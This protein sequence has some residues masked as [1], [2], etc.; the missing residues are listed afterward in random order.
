VTSGPA[1]F[2][3]TNS[4][5]PSATLNIVNDGTYTVQLFVDN[6]A[7]STGT[8]VSKT[9][10]VSANSTFAQ[11]SAVF[12]NVNYGCTGCHAF[13][14]GYANNPDPAVNSGIPPSWQSPNDSNGKT[15]YQ[16]VL[17]RVNLGSPASSLLL[18]NPL[19]SSVSPNTNGHGGGQLFTDEND[20]AY[21][22][23]LTW[24]IGNAPP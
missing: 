24:I 5:L 4:T 15:L 12:T 7:L 11:V 1:G 10:T 20:T 17:D 8:A 18:L 21:V 2:S 3:I 19:N 16:R 13:G 9:I 22:T 23:F 6:G 14:I